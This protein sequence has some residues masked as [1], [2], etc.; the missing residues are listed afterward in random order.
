MS[1][2]VDTVRCTGCEF[3]HVDHHGGVMLEYRCGDEVV[4]VGYRTEAW[5]ED[6]QTLRP[7]ESLPSVEDLVERVSQAEEFVRGTP[8]QQRKDQTGSPM[9]RRRLR[10]MEILGRRRTALAWRR[11]RVSAPRC[12][13][14]GGTRWRVP[15]WQL[16]DSRDH[17]ITT[18]FRHSCG[19]VLVRFPFDPVAALMQPVK[20]Y[21]LDAEGR[22][23]EV[24]DGVD[25]DVYFDALEAPLEKVRLGRG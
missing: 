11:G 2:P 7:I 21:V 20:R 23:I 22:V 15:D 6:C 3:E 12:L 19:G 17:S 24:R 14:C 16:A 8:W 1:Y 5:C 9:D 18:E 4:H 10:A 13:T 25:F